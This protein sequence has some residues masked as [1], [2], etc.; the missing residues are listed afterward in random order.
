MNALR[1]ILFLLTCL[2][3]QAGLERFL[4]A[5]I[6]YVDMMVLPVVWYAL[7]R[8]QRSA[9]LVGCAGGLLQDAWFQVGIFGLNGF[10]KTFLGWILGSLA[11]R[12]D[13]GA[14]SNRFIVGFLFSAAKNPLELGLRRL[15]D[16]VTVAPSITAWLVEAAVSGLLVVITF[17]ILKRLGRDSDSRRLG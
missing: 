10:T 7:E 15:M 4:P 9:M 8:S 16:Q 6:G 5:S 1:P 17:A 11:V 3:L 13:L 14:W 2:V 12:F